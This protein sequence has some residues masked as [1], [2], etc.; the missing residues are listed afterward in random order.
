MLSG[1]GAAVPEER[2]LLSILMQLVCG[3]LGPS[4]HP[5]SASK[6]QGGVLDA[7]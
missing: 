6:S 5:L 7:L 1:Q 4:A 3:G 2:T